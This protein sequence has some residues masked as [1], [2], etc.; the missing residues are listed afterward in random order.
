MKDFFI[1]FNF[2]LQKQLKSTVF[3]VVTF[4]L[5]VISA[6]SVLLVGNFIESPSQSL[7]YVVDQT[8]ELEVLW[9]DEI[10]KANGVGNMVFDLS[11]IDST[12]S[13]EE[14]LHQA[15]ERNITVVLFEASQNDILMKITDDT[16]SIGDITLM[17]E[18]VKLAVQN[19]RVSELDISQ[20]N[21][22]F[23]TPAVD[24]KIDSLYV[25]ENFFLVIILCLLMIMFIILYSNAAS[26][27]VSYLKTNRVM[28]LFSTSVKPL[29]LY[30]GVNLSAAFI[31]F[32]QLL[33]MI[34]SALLSKVI[35]NIDL[36]VTADSMGI[37]LA[38]LDMK[39]IFL[40][41]VF[42]LLGFF[43]YSFINTALASIVSKA[44]DIMSLTVPVAFVALSQYFVGMMVFESDTVFT[45]ICSYFPL[46]SP[47]IMFLRYFLNRV[48]LINVAI[49]II[50]LVITISVLCYIGSKL[51]KFGVVYY[52]NLGGIFKSK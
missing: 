4:L 22:S 44:E 36:S 45:N 30:I 29:P 47:S 2:F 26:N 24:V 3:L 20:E 9:N 18:T 46:T 41:L 14:L 34:A 8:N 32:L 52:G 15:G 21:L 50:I 27:E 48:E 6:V 40:F 35:F 23:I 19:T 51:F 33:L 7:V 17:S 13:Y 39:T 16:I 1:V 38:N 43:V 11:M 49:S 12:D 31:P 10:I 25:S 28:E 42:F 37:N 5:C